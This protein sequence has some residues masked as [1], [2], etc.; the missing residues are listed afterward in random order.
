MASGRD[1]G[2]PAFGGSTTSVFRAL[3]VPTQAR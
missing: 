1:E 2:L 3:T